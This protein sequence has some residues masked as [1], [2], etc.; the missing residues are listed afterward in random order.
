MPTISYTLTREALNEE[1]EEEI[2][3]TVTYTWHRFIGGSRDGRGGPLIEPDEP[4][5]GEI[6]SITRDDT[7]AEIDTTDAEDERIQEA[8]NEHAADRETD[9]CDEPSR[10]DFDD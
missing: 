7:G 10:S 6:E 8:V 3:V 2:D 9:Y 1:G 5:H 4:A